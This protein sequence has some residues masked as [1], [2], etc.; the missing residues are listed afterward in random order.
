MG[1]M[2]IYE[3]VCVWFDVVN[4][5]TMYDYGDHVAKAW[6]QP[7]ESCDGIVRRIDVTIYNAYPQ[8]NG[9]IVLDY[10]NIG[11]VPAKLV[12]LWLDDIGPNQ[13]WPTQDWDDEGPGDYLHV[14]VEGWYPDD[15]DRA[16]PGQLDPCQVG[17]LVLGFRLTN[18]VD[19]G[20]EYG[21]SLDTIW[22][23]WNE[24]MEPYVDTIPWTTCCR[25]AGYYIYDCMTP[26]FNYGYVPHWWEP[27]YTPPGGWP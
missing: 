12:E 25:P 8:L 14:W 10:H 11:T 7:F 16:Y 9:F 24:P 13:G 2:D 23:N 5:K 6:I 22:Y 21:F 27:Y 4:D 18:D 15:N 17:Y 1:R 3:S 20:A 19:E 26:D